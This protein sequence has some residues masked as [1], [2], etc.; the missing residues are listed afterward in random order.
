[1][2]DLQVF[3]ICTPGGIEQSAPE[4]TEADLEELKN[5]GIYRNRVGIRAPLK[6]LATLTDDAGSGASVTDIIDI[7][8]HLGVVYVLSHS[9]ATDKVYLHKMQ[10]DGSNVNTT[11]GTWPGGA[12]PPI[13]LV[14]YSSV[15]TK[16]TLMLTSF[17]GGT[18]ASP[19]TRLYVS[20]YDQTLATKYL[21][22]SA[23]SFTTLGVDFDASGS[24]EDAKFS[25]MK[26]FKFHLWGTGFFEAAVLRPEMLR[27]S[28]P[29]TI[30]GTDIA[31]GANP[32]EWWTAD[33]RSVGRRG[34]KIVALEV[35]GDRLLVFQKRATHAIYGSGSTTWTR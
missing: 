33:H 13:P 31:G 3:P 8:E 20:D 4:P 6:L 34:D 5:F 27:F 19:E 21:A 28:Q 7:A 2:S 24:N 26:S 32:R 16:P 15:A 1:M 18:A 22:G 11:G 14:V 17:T 10:T 9:T 35:A 25:L 23:T 30:P 29:G 12:D